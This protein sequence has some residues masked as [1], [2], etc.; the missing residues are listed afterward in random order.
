MDFTTTIGDDL[1]TG[2]RR[3]I[4]A[5]SEGESAFHV[6]AAA[7]GGEDPRLLLLDR[8]RRYGRAASALRALAREQGIA[9]RAERT[10]DGPIRLGRDTAARD[11]AAIVMACEPI[12]DA[13]LVAYRDALEFALPEP[14]R[15][16]VERE[17]DGLIA[18][19]GSLRALRE[20]LVA[21]NLGVTSAWHL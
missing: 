13:A 16:V 21:R 11:D 1:R 14:V 8:A 5:T 15:A 10:T 18:S 6:A 4:H 2:L 12:E 17:F 19:L 9:I 20:R 7:V 3:V